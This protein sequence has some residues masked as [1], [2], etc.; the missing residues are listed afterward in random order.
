MEGYNQSNYGGFEKQNSPI[1]FQG[2]KN[3]FERRK[4]S[5]YGG[6]SYGNCATGGFIYWFCNI[7]YRT[8]SHNNTK[9]YMIYFKE[10]TVLSFYVNVQNFKKSCFPGSGNF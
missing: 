1:F 2:T 9:Q 8:L 7:S 6:L 3:S 5:G 4:H 10:S